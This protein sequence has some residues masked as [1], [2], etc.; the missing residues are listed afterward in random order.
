MYDFLSIFN[1]I[2]LNEQ[3]KQARFLTR[4]LRVN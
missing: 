1:I 4:G 3:I 2:K